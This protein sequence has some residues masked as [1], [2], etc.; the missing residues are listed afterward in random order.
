[1]NFAQLLGDRGLSGAALKESLKEVEAQMEEER[2]EAAIGVDVEM[3]DVGGEGMVGEG[4]GET[5]MPDD[6]GVNV[7]QEQEQEVVAV[8]EEEDIVEDVRPAPSAK[9]RGKKAQRH[10]DVIEVSYRLSCFSCMF[11]SLTRNGWLRSRMTRKQ[12]LRN[13]SHLA[14]EPVM[15]DF[16]LRRPKMQ[17]LNP[18]NVDGQ[19]LGNASQGAKRKRRKN[20]NNLIRAQLP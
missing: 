16:P 2:R 12:K 14:L 4:Q 15:G 17:P 19:F 11:D 18:K 20:N 5:E 13:R 7:E 8:Q 3:N 6:G 1:M 9:A 10:E